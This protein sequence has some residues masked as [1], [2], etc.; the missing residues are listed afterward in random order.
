[1]LLTIGMIMKNE[2][3]FLRDCLTAIKP[4]L[5]NVDSELVICDTGSTDNS[6]AIAKEFTKNVFEIEWRDDFGWARQQGFE[7]AKG[8]WFLVLDADEIFENVQNIVDFFNSGEYKNYG[9]ATVKIVEVFHEQNQYVAT[10]KPCRLFKIINGMHWHDKIHERLSPFAEPTK[11]LNSTIL[12][13]GNTVEVVHENNKT[14]KYIEYMLT[15]LE[16]NPTNYKNIFFLF[17]KIIGIYD[18]S[19]C[20]KY[21]DLGLKLAKKAELDEKYPYSYPLF[22]PLFVHVYISIYVQSG[23][24]QKIIDITNEY[25]DQVPKSQLTENAFFLKYQQGLAFAMQGNFLDAS[26]ALLDAYDFKKQADNNKLFGIFSHIL[27]PNI[28][29]IDF[30]QNI[31]QAYILANLFETAVE[32]LE[33]LPAQRLTADSTI[34][35]NREECY[36]S[37][38]NLLII[39]NPQLLNNLAQH[40]ENK[41]GKNSQNYIDIVN[42]IESAINK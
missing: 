29:D 27:L 28:A 23:E 33:N 21:G 18:I 13:Y 39:H 40:F 24:Y 16:E 37:F 30:I 38:V 3:R 12:H 22:Y 25:F 34:A 6:I 14:E 32:Y 7:R 17:S 11:N 5:D 20:L 10:G 15:V 9:T 1:M 41:Y 8:E 42:I 2:E 26:K 4:I 35:I 19:I 31:L 36:N